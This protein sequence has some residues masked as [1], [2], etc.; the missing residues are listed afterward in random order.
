MVQFLSVSGLL[1]GGGREKN[2][3]LFEKQKNNSL[4]LLFSMTERGI[5]YALFFCLGKGGCRGILRET[6]FLGRGLVL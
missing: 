3:G 4:P 2:R 5:F 1:P 6:A